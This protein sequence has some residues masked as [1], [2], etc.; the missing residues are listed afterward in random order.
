[1]AV[2]I[3]LFGIPGAG[4]TTYRAQL[5]EKLRAAGLEVVD[6]GPLPRTEGRFPWS[7]RSE[8]M[9]LRR[10]GLC[11]RN[12]RVLWWCL[13]VLRRSPRP[14]RQ[15]VAAFRVVFV[16]LERYKAFQRDTSNRV[17]IIDEGSL[18]RLSF[19]SWRETASG[20]R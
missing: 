12:R 14:F 10:V 19:F 1:M 3:E 5:V 17:Y 11:L 2:I 4:K 13:N 9:A 6:L 8:A 18:Q 16:G 20:S 7:R 15:K